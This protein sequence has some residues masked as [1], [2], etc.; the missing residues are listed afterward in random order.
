M[1]VPD[2]SKLLKE[3]ACELG[4]KISSGVTTVSLLVTE[5]GGVFLAIRKFAF[6][7]RDTLAIFPNYGKRILA[8]SK[9]RLCTVPSSHNLKLSSSNQSRPTHPAKEDTISSEQ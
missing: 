2:I 4:I 1:I 8:P 5:L 6:F 9:S 3:N 7:F